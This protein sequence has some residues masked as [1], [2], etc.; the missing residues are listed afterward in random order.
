MR[1]SKQI[2]SLDMSAQVAASN[3]RMTVQGYLKEIVLDPEPASSRASRYLCRRLGGGLSVA[4]CQL[5]GAGWRGG[6]SWC[7]LS[8]PKGRMSGDN[9]GEQPEEEG[10]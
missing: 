1:V 3:G 4:L 7:R 10:L 9:A 5:S 2:N 8:A 6:D